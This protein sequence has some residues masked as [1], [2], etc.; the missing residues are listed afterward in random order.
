MREKRACRGDGTSTWVKKDCEGD[1]EEWQEGDYWI[2]G[3]FPMTRLTR[4][5]ELP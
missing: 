2:A 4:H 3:E 1:R 5:C